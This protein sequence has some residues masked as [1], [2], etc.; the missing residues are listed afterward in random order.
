LRFLR[1]FRAPFE[2]VIAREASILQHRYPRN[3]DYSH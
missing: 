1:F 3:L 2:G